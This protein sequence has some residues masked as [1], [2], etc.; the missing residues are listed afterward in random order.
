MRQPAGP[1]ET[2]GVETTR[3]SSAMEASSDSEKI[4]AVGD[5]LRRVGDE[6]AHLLNRVAQLEARAAQYHAEVTELRSLMKRHQGAESGALVQ[7][8][9]V[10]DRLWAGNLQLVQQH[11]EVAVHRLERA[12]RDFLE[13]GTGVAARW[14]GGCEEVKTLLRLDAH[15][16][17]AGQAAKRCT[18]QRARGGDTQASSGVETETERETVAGVPWHEDVDEVLQNTERMAQERRRSLALSRAQELEVS[19]LLCERRKRRIITCV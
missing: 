17:C 10:W 5:A 8:A 4:K 3:K 12:C 7:K 18:L 11:T 1:V 9:T 13:V 16:A 2:R 6:Q 14:S 15:A 19:R